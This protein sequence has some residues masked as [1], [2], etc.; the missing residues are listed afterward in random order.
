[1][2]TV[3]ILDDYHAIEE[4]ALHEGLFFFLEHLPA[5]LHL[6]LSTRVDPDFPLSR[7]RARGQ[8]IEIRAAD[9]RFT[10]T[11]ASLFLTEVMGLSLARTERDSGTAHRGVDRGTPI[12]RALPPETG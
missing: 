9:L 4:K 8:L 10:A 12:D 3:L 1:M 7:W 2:E 11:E 6:I 5:D